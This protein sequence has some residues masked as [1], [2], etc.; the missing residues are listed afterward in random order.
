MRYSVIF[1]ALFAAVAFSVGTAL[2]GFQGG[3][4]WGWK[5]VETA[6][7]YT[8]GLVDDNGACSVFEVTADSYADAFKAARESC[9]N[10]RVDNI[11]GK[12][13]HGEASWDIL[14]MSEMYCI[15]R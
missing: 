7:T 6:K 13:Y 15:I 2:A 4:D 9:L 3:Y 14:P 8:F 10:C 11:T 5:P 1:M 12:T